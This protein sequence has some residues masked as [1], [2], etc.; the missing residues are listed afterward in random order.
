MNDL[1]LVTDKLRQIVASPR[2]RRGISHR[3]F[4]RS[5]ASR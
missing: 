5:A 1:L 4:R 3:L 2:L